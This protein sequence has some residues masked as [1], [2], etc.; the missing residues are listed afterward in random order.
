MYLILTAYSAPVTCIQSPSAVNFQVTHP[1]H[2]PHVPQ[3][4]ERTHRCAC[5]HTIAPPEMNPRGETERMIVIRK[6]EAR[7]LSSH[8]MVLSRA[9]GT[10]N[11]CFSPLFVQFNLSLHSLSNA[12]SICECCCVGMELVQERA[13]QIS[14]QLT[15]RHGRKQPA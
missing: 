9:Y 13:C 12:N 8:Q 3:F 2:P 1:P 11:Y 14:L 10:E 6:C 7:A 5:A 4:P 15:Q